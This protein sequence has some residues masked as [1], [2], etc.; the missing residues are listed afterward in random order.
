MVE[1]RVKWF[2]FN[3]AKCY[4]KWNKSDKNGEQQAQRREAPDIECAGLDVIPNRYIRHAR[5]QQ[6]GSCH[7][8]DEGG[9]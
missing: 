7:R 8:T 3:P 2:S 5:S 6:Q 1:S 4:L 9:A